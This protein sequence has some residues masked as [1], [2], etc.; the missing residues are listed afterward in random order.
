MLSVTV[1]FDNALVF[2]SMW[3][4]TIIYN[5]HHHHWQLIR[6]PLQGLSGDVQYHVQTQTD[7]LTFSIRL[8]AAIHNW[9]ETWWTIALQWTTTRRTRDKIGTCIWQRC[10]YWISQ[11]P[12]VCFRLHD[13]TTL[14][15]LPHLSIQRRRHLIIITRECGV[16]M[17]L[18]TSVCLC[19]CLF[20]S[21]S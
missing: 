2:S 7:S 4:A 11:Y 5:R 3:H 10:W 12:P 21:C 20:C 17:C 6:H 14:H 13:T 8:T 19:V 15:Q 9:T 16:V 1:F 18:V